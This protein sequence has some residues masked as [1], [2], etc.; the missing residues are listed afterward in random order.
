M[1]NDD[2]DRLLL[3]D[4]SVDIEGATDGVAEG[5]GVDDGILERIPDDIFEQVF[6]GFLEGTT[7]GF[8]EGLTDGSVENDS[9][10]SEQ[11]QMLK[12][13]KDGNPSLSE[14]K[15][16]SMLKVHWPVAR[17]RCLVLLYTV[18]RFVDFNNYKV[19]L[20]YDG[21]TIDDCINMQKQAWRFVQTLSIK[22]Y[23]NML[24]A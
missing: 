1:T 7:D 18:D 10:T 24:H 3:L 13:H 14:L 2:D 17:R 23:D 20:V 15:V 11:E 12:K 4:G 6:D 19:K 16:H 22:M 9:L 8:F 21:G 5:E